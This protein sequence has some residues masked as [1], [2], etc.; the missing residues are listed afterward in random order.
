MIVEGEEDQGEN[1]LF[2]N[3]GPMGDD[4]GVIEESLHALNGSL[5]RK[6]ITVKGSI[7]RERI[8]LLIDTGTSGSYLN[9]H[10]VQQLH[11]PS[12]QIDPVMVTL[13][14]GHTVTCTSL[15]SQ[16]KW[17]IQGYNLCFCFKAMELAGW[18]MV[19]GVD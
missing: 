1:S 6:T 7:K 12:A 15:Y 9:N 5:D 11:L 19:L 2:E 16:V 13:G 3:E 14:N 17:K 10:L 18:D 4:K 8:K